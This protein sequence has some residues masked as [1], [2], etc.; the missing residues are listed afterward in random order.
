M[1]EYVLRHAST[2]QQLRRFIDEEGYEIL[3]N[4]PGGGHA[5]CRAT[6][7]WWLYKGDEQ[8]AR[9]EQAKRWVHIKKSIDDYYSQPWV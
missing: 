7:G 6:G 5:D 1:T 4:T 8:L 2:G 3:H 9:E